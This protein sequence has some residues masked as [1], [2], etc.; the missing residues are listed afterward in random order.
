MSAS[1]VRPWTV[2]PLLING[3]G[4]GSSGARPP[5]AS[6]PAVHQVS[7]DWA[8]GNS[9]SLPPDASQIQVQCAIEGPR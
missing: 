9:G 1:R 2:L 7:G 6:L 5:V 8:D 4:S 3:C